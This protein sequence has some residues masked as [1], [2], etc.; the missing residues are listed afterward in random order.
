M[1]TFTLGQRPCMFDFILCKHLQRPSILS[2]DFLRKYKLEL[3]GQ[4]MKSLCWSKKNQV[5]IESVDSQIEGLN[6]TTVCNI[7]TPPRTLAVINIQVDP[8]TILE[9]HLPDVRPSEAHVM[10]ILIWHLCQSYTR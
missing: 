2:I 9:G 6:I 5:L 1:C 10:S 7:T 4:P 3:V 8:K